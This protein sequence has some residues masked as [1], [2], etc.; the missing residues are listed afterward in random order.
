MNDNDIKRNIIVSVVGLVSILSLL[1]FE[2]SLVGSDINFYLLL[3]MGLGLILFIVLL[4]GALKEKQKKKKLIQEL[5]DEL[6]KDK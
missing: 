6:N 1:L 2:I 5:D 4:I 3:I